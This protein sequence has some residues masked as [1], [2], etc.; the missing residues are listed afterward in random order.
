MAL[1]STPR[2]IYLLFP[3]WTWVGREKNAV[4]LT[5]DDGPNKEFTPWL[6]TFLKDRNVK[7]TFFCV[8]DRARDFPELI[9]QIT[10]EGHAIGNHTMNHENG[11]KTKSAD[12]L[13]SVTQSKSYINSLLFRPPYGK[14]RIS[15][16]IKLRMIGFKII[17]WT[18]LS[19]DFD[20]SISTPL[21]LAKS[22]KIKGGD[23][24][25]FHDNLKS[26]EKTKIIL[27]CLI[28]AMFEKGLCFKILT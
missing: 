22:K 24:L 8:G 10:A 19:N 16:S 27:P 9:Q 3:K 13:A 28:D 20:A 17:M 2:I 18:W 1:F 14:I 11:W 12:Y 25:V 23:I 21:I 7:A 15:Q 4:Y 26:I 5:F 6:L